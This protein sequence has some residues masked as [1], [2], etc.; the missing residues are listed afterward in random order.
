MPAFVDSTFIAVVAGSFAASV[1]NAMFSAGGALIV[2][3][4][5]STVL[6]IQHIVPIHSTLLIG[7]TTT[8]VVF[9]WSFIDWKIVWPFILGSLAGAII[10]ARIYIELPEAFIATAIAVL[11]LVALWLPSIKW[12]PR[13]HH[14]WVI[15]GFV[16]TFISTLFAYGALLHSVILHTGL[17]RR[18]IVG[19]MAGALT[20][21]VLFKTAG[22]VYYGFDYVPYLAMIGAAILMSFA[23]T[24]VGKWLGDSLSESKFRLAY[25]ILVTLT[26]LRLMYTGL[27]QGVS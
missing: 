25:R 21:M 15:V 4:V 27:M 6:P 8:R 23:G 17:E 7:S 12:R 9:F 16:H 24:A 22:Y 13:I 11:M 19:T 14:P 20:G 3:A 26:A 2:I 10:G 1:A 5:T 18:Q